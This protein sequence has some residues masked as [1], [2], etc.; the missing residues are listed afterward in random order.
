MCQGDVKNTPV[1]LQEL[2]YPLLY[3]CH[4]FRPDSGG[5][6]KYRGGVGVEVKVTPLHDMLVSRN[7]D[8][9][10]CP[11]WGLLGGEEGAVNETI[12]QRNG[13]KETLPGKFSHLLVHPGESVT[14]LTAG[15]GGYGDPAERDAA[16]VKRDVE[17]GYVSKE[18]AEGSCPTA[19]NR[20]T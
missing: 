10:K 6:G 7:T 15:G 14:F 11:P 13:N 12:L 5:A 4:K 19:F 1:E 20:K 2:Y 3:E 8:R 16:S 9:I 17:L 18:K